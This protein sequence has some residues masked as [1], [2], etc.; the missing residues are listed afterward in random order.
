MLLHLT[1]RERSAVLFFIQHASAS[2]SIDIQ[3]SCA[4][5]LFS[6]DDEEGAGAVAGSG[7]TMNPDRDYTYDEVWRTKDQFPHAPPRVC[8]PAR[9]FFF[10]LMRPT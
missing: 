5:V 1:A 7:T 6:D 2:D 10:F 9:F 4:A 3:L 8:F